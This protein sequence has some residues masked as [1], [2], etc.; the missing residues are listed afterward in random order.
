MKKTP[1]S[2]QPGITSPSCQKTSRQNVVK[3]NILYFRTSGGFLQ[4]LIVDNEWILMRGDGTGVLGEK[5]L[6]QVENDRN[7]LCLHTTGRGVVTK[8][9]NDLLPPKT[10]QNHL[11]PPTTIYNDLQP[12]RKIQ[13]PSTTTSK[14]STT[15]HKQSNTILNKP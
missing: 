7:S 1:L 6:P 3:V 4:A 13:Q 12:P 14:T 10:T 11:K 8:R 15:T 9:R 2:S 5:L